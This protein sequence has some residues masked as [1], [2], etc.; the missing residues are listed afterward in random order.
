MA[1]GYLLLFMV[2]ALYMAYR[3]TSWLDKK[4]VL[5]GGLATI[6]IVW[7]CSEA[8]WVVAEVGRQPWVIQD[9]MP[10]RAAISSIDSGS[11]QFT[12][13]V[14]VAVFTMLLAAEVSIMVN[15]IRKDSKQD[16]LKK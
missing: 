16:I 14:F 13:W 12:F 9:L 4:L 15:E 11:V 8:G 7:I 1:G 10:A 3:K 2:L 5:W 6:A